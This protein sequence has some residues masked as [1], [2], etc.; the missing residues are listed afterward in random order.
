MKFLWR[1]FE[2]DDWVI[3][4]SETGKWVRAG[5]TVDYAYY[6]IEFSESR[7]KYRISLDGCDPKGHSLYGEMLK[8]LAK[9]NVELLNDPV[10]KR[11]K[12]LR[13]LGIK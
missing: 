3:I 2:K 9:L 6:N 12:K 8:K 1:L 11:D 10:E 7:N 4:D 5:K 13:Q